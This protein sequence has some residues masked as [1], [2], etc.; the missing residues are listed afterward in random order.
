M[1]IV[2]MCSSHRALLTKWGEFT[3]VIMRNVYLDAHYFIRRSH[4]IIYFPSSMSLFL[5]LCLSVY[6]CVC[7]RLLL[8]VRECLIKRMNSE[9]IA[10]ETL[11]LCTFADLCFA[12]FIGAFC[13]CVVSISSMTSIRRSVKFEKYNIQHRFISYQ[14]IHVDRLISRSVTNI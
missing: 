5:S 10:G 2:A 3:K 1:F 11:F 8:P 7:F 9:L 4:D 13:V 12:K 6:L 14:I